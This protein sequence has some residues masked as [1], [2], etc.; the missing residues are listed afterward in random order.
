M[1]RF[2]LAALACALARPVAGSATIITVSNLASYGEGTLYSA[3]NAANTS[4]PPVTITFQYTGAPPFI[5]RLTND[6]LH[7]LTNQVSIDGA[8]QPGYAGVPLVWLDGSANGPPGY[9][10]LLL[11]CNNA[12][13]RALRISGFAGD[14]I[15]IS[16]GGG[17]NSAVGC[18]ITSNYTGISVFN[19]GNIIGGLSPSN[20]NIIA[21]NQHFG[22][23][24][25]GAGSA[26]NAILGNYIGVNPTNTDQAL[27]NAESGILVVDAPQTLI[28][29]VSSARQIVAGSGGD[30]IRIEGTGA[31]ESVIAGNWV[32]LGP[33]GTSALA[34]AGNGIDIF[35]STRNRIGGTNA[36]DMNVVSGNGDSGIAIAQTL[37]ASNVVLGNRIGL[38][39][40]GLTAVGNTGSGIRVIGAP[41][42]LIGGT[43][44]G[45]TNYIAGNG[46]IGILLT[47]G[48]DRCRVE[49]N[50][51]GVL[52]ATLLGNGNS[53]IFVGSSY[54]T[55][56]GGSNAA[57]RNIV[58]GSTSYG[59][60]LEFT[61]NVAVQGNFVGS[62]GTVFR[63]PNVGGGVYVFKSKLC[64]VGGTS[65]GARNIISGN[66]ASGVILDQ[67]CDSCDVLGNYIGLNA[68]GNI[69]ISNASFAVTLI[70]TTNCHIGGAAPG[71]GNVIASC[72]SA[73][74]NIQGLARSNVVAGNLIGLAADGTT[75][76][77]DSGSYGVAVSAS[78]NTVGGP[79]PEERNVIAASDSAGV[80]IHACTGV[81]VQGNFIGFASN[82][83]TALPASP[84]G[85]WLTLGAAGCTIGGAAP[86][87]G[88][89]IN[90]S[91][92]GIRLANSQSNTIAGNAVGFNAPES[93]A[94]TGLQHAVY[95]SDA[96]YN[97]IGG[98]AAGAGNA[99]VGWSIALYLGESNTHHNVVQGN[100]INLNHA[101]LIVATNNDAA[102]QCYRSPSNT[103][104]G[105]AAGAR[106]V[107][108][109][110]GNGVML[111][112]TSCVENVFQGNYIGVGPDGHS[113]RAIGGIAGAG[114][115]LQDGTARNRMGGTNAGE[116][117]IIAYRTAGGIAIESNDL[118]IGNA[119]LGNLVYSNGL[120]WPGIDLTA[121]SFPA[122]ND[123]VPDS[124]VGPNQM[125]NYPV[126][127]NAI[128]LTGSTRIQGYL[129]SAPSRT[130]RLEFF[131]ADA[132]IREG[133]FFLGATNVTT[134]A[135]GTGTFSVVLNGY[136]ATS[137]W[138]T[139][140]ATDPSNNTSEFSAQL[141]ATLAADTDG[142]GMP[143]FWESQFGLNP[144]VSNAPG[145]DLDA[146]GA[147]DY[148]EYIAA[149]SPNDA[150]SLL[151][152]A[153]LSPGATNVV[154][155]P[156][157]PYRTYN[158]EFATNVTS[159]WSLQATNVLGNG[160]LGSARNVAPT[161]PANYRVRA[162]VP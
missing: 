92:Y 7:Y 1:K 143:D 67:G 127:T 77:V 153:G 87:A 9:N 62:D 144:A 28:Q 2:L 32:G 49:G 154:T 95:L 133:R 81:V 51:V 161:S 65:A 38:S 151:E 19:G 118:S 107:L 108:T 156:T 18:W 75:P 30:G 100:F 78:Y 63:R 14:G 33:A 24:L 17:H 45:S 37:T 5:I 117:N 48:S 44:P 16:G 150:S 101:G 86:G 102:I 35:S 60:E 114:F 105:A 53:G 56:I 70:D 47:E 13:V 68:A 94:M 27:G 42:T 88:N 74:V 122:L 130:Y 34:N 82:G 123:N 8:S 129:P 25:S 52:A 80:E 116:G 136:A 147:S 54:A 99:L 29:G 110:R 6:F 15:A 134:A 41:E 135:N 58:I 40:V 11:Q 73:G 64:Q 10:G 4:P 119:I 20:R 158:L 120:F 113:P 55:V 142:D 59:I 109:S 46:Q 26:S 71:A 146:D 137:R 83:V 138:I 85:I 76:I 79:T 149:T 23:K 3:V 21:G 12:T 89:V 132:F 50:Q 111:L 124:D 139:A 162:V 131:A 148:A 36:A 104:G 66:N 112:G 160:L 125:Q 145:A 126:L 98:T 61:T 115:F 91:G 72:G 90:A 159:A 43:A 97:L 128:T 152:V 96:R 155:F 121:D 106:N 39:A 103:F 157:S 140:T 22:V 84:I 141:R 93:V 57:A 69:A 31:V